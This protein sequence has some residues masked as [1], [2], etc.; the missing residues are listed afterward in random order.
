MAGSVEVIVQPIEKIVAIV[1]ARMRSSR[2][3]GKVLAE[4]A[5]RSMLE[6]I[7]SRVALSRFISQV[8]IATS[9]QNADDA[10]AAVAA[11]REFDVYRGSETDVL[12]RYYRAARSVNADVVV[13]ITG[14][15]PFTDPEVI[16][17]VIHSF[18][19]GDCDYASN[20]LVCTY[21]DGLDVEVFSVA[22]LEAAWLEGRR[23]ADREHVTPYIRTSGR[24]RLRNVE[25]DMGRPTQHLRWT[26]DDEADLK[27]VRVIYERIQCDQFGCRD[28]LALLDAE[29]WIGT[30]N[31]GQ[32]RNE[33]FYRSLAREPPTPVRPRSLHESGQLARRME[34]VI[35]GGS[36]TLSKGPTQYVQGVA[37]GFLARAYGSHVW[38]VDGNEYIDLPMALGAVILGHCYPAV[39]ESVRRQMTQG[40]SFSLPHALEVEAAELL[41]E[42]VPCAEMVRFGKNGSDATAGAVRLARAYTG[43]DL[44]ACCG[45][46]GWQ[47]WYIGTTSFSG[48]VPEVIRQLTRTF[49]YNDVESLKRV[50]EQNYKQVAAVILEPIGVVE[51]ADGFLG[52]VRDLCRREGCLLIFDEVIT[53]FRLASGGA[54]EYFG[55]VPDLACFGK[56]LAN[57]YPLSAIVGRREIMKGFEQTFFSFTFGGEA[58]SLAASVATMREICGRKVI[59]QIWEQGQ[60]I[61]DGLKCLGRE[62]GAEG[63]VSC[64]GLPPRSVVNFAD[65]SGRESLLVKSL[66]QQE[67]LKRGVLFSGGQN[68]CYSHSDQDIEYVL[69]VY[70]AA[71]EATGRAIRNGC[72]PQMLEGSPVQPVFRRA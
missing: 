56:A 15:C 9:T 46:H 60:K 68:I 52:E 8:I 22:A 5:G 31:L 38:D 23:S 32:I 59:P 24:F 67:C 18:L 10:I 6:H 41:V 16:D 7:V 35:P 64:L 71:L 65:E 44:I 40:T 3:P 1:Q 58:L 70:R 51:P 43:R 49:E 27:F 45:Y 21:P 69:R 34:N 57:G 20:T 28:V 47:D 11:E 12:D 26:V 61:K 25:S 54:Q 30:L 42:L 2:L 62:F 14:D 72:V 4:I 39:E 53:G 37:P 63:F 17:R 33:G 19:K 36:Q 48:G 50:F 66:F 29:P 13:R 55:V